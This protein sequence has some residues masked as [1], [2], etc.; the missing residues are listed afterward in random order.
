LHLFSVDFATKWSRESVSWKYF[1]PACISRFFSSLGPGPAQYLLPPSVGYER[2]DPRKYRNPMFSFGVRPG[3]KY[4]TIGPG[5]GNYVLGTKTRYGERNGP[6]FSMGIRLK[7]Q[8]HN[9]GPGPGA[10]MCKLNPEAPQFSFGLRTSIPDK[11]KN[12]G[13]DR[14]FPQL[15]IYKSRAPEFTM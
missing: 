1:R 10:Y 14:Y 15:N 12:P 9:I 8:G 7:P 2:H 5:P 6:Q 3:L 13:P 11:N 4:A